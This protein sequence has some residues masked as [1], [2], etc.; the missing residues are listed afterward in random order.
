MVEVFGMILLGAFLYAVATLLVARRL[1]RGEPRASER[2]DGGCPDCGGELKRRHYDDCELPT[3][4]DCGGIWCDPSQPGQRRLAGFVASTT[5]PPKRCP[6][7]RT[8]TLRLGTA[9]MRSTYSCE[10][11]GGWFRRSFEQARPPLS[12]PHVAF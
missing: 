10:A 3:C 11:C 4:A 1:R 5:S 8:D 7:C 9:M 12:A 2:R 6:T